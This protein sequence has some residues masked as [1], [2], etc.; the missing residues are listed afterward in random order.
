MA[1]EKPLLS[2]VAPAFNEQEVLPAFHAELSKTLDQLSSEY[3]LEVIYVDDGSRDDTPLVLQ[4]LAQED[5]RVHYVLL[6]RNF[7]H[8]AA[9]TA[10]LV[11]ARGDI[12]ISMDSDLQHPPPVILSLLEKWKEGYQV[13]L[14]IREDDETISWFKKTS[15][16]L[17][18]RVLQRMS[19]MEIRPAA[20]DFRLLTR[21]ALDVFLK[22][23]ERNRFIRGMIHWLGFP[24][25]EVHFKAAPRFAG[26]SK[27]TLVKMIRFARDGLLSFSRV[28]LHAALLLAGFLIGL[29]FLFSLGVWTFRLGNDENRWMILAMICSFHICGVGIWGAMLAISEYLSRIHEQILGRPLYVV[30]NSSFENNL[31]ALRERDNNA[32]RH[33]A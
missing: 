2:I 19:G 27:Y 21:K 23:P 12:V 26:K 30:R 14:T 29:S 13:V 15:S 4:S 22:M 18:Y 5:P 33:A 28:P 6:S 32:T 16:K 10:G 17:F 11:H 8:Q 25:A 20:A 31:A 24:S 3:D 1:S 9:L 7:G